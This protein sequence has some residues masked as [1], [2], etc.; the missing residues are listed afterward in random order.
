MDLSISSSFGGAFPIPTSTFIL[1]PKSR[2]SHSLNF[3]KHRNSYS[4]NPLFSRQK[5]PI[6]A[7]VS[8]P[9]VDDGLVIDD[10]PHLTD[11]LPDLPVFTSLFSLHILFFVIFCFR[12]C[13]WFFFR[14]WNCFSW[15]SVEK[16]ILVMIRNFGL[17]LFGVDNKLEEKI[18]KKKKKKAKWTLLI[19][20]IKKNWE[21]LE[22]KWFGVKLDEC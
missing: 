11:F 2:C 7:Q 15:I 12:D 21:V 19:K 8:D 1:N 4:K 14:V 22:Y 20:K 13:C 16:T 9:A 3:F 18:W 17:L 10:V 5:I 6:R